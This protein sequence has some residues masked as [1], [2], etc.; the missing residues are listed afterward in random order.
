MAAVANGLCLHGGVRG[1]GA[2]FLVFS[3]YMRPALRLAALMQQPSLMVFTHDSI[4]LGEDG[5]THQPIEHLM[6]L[7][8]MPNYWV[9]RPGDANEVRDCWQMAL[10][11]KDG[12][13]ALVLT[14]QNVP[15]IDKRGLGGFGSPTQGAYVLADASEGG[16][17]PEAIIIATGSEVEI[18]LEAWESLR[19]AGVKARVVSMPC[20]EAFEAQDG[21]YQE[22][23]LPK[24][25]KARVSIEAGATLGWQ[26]WIGFE[27]K[28]IGLDHFGASAPYEVLYEKFGLTAAKVEEAV[29]GLLG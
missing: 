23:V 1:F 29:K 21:E 4:G 20:W 12:P 3:D 9:F 5:P 25:V 17:E 6:S 15:T 22:Q 13:S 28:A 11:R 27:G 2:T 18:A 8:A 14:R 26:R 10:E 16:K 24:R 19:E 7:R